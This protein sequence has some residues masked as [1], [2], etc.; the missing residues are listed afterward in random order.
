MIR[1]FRYHPSTTQ[2]LE[3][4]DR[5]ELNFQAKKPPLDLL[6]F[7]VLTPDSFMWKLLLGNTVYY[8]YAEDYIAGMDELKSTIRYYLKH[9][10]WN[11]VPV[12]D[13]DTHTEPIHDLMKVTFKSGHDY[14]TLIKT[15]ENPD[16]ALF[17]DK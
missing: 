17:Y 13:I 7:E 12:R 14:V 8:L 2:I 3:V 11:F 5:F 1:D 9:D 10:K 15:L 4:L 16:D 6:R